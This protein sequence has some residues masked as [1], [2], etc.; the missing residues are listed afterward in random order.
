MKI[1][2]LNSI[3]FTAE[4]NVI[5]KVKSI[6]DTMI[7]NLCIGFKN[8]GHNVTLAAAEEYK[9]I[10][11]EDYNFD[12]LFFKSKLKKIFLPSVLPFSPSLFMYLKKNA[13]DFDF[14]IS[15]EIFAFP[16]LFAC[17][18]CPSKVFVWQE[19][20][21]HNRKMCKIPSK[22]W[23]NII[24][25]IFMRRCLVVPRSHAACMF[26]SNYHR[27]VASNNISHGIDFSK[28]QYSLE[29]LEYFITVGRLVPG[30]NIKSIILRFDAFL[31]KYN[32]SKYR[33]Y[34][35]G[36]GELLE[37]LRTFVKDIEREDSVLFLGHLPHIE[38]NKYLS[39]AKA[40]LLNSRME[41]N[42][43]SLAES[44]AV[45]TPVITNTVPYSSYDVIQNKLGIAKDDWDEDDMME[46]IRNNQFYVDNCF[47]YR[48]QLSI[49]TIANKFIDIFSKRKDSY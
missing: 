30:K 11:K 42:M 23:Y 40:T 37:E 39:Q 13:K 18:I 8:L 24:T 41:L 33:L 35:A 43:I 31:K 5:P 14:I 34:I 10:E 1:L 20:G 26:I 21:V 25:P 6:K 44:V 2:I 47:F 22:I 38:L 12:I 16:T 17:M 48:E 4:K 7:Y 3:L 29:K 19:L 15:S 28:L 32:L 46:V 36:N 9:P 27:N 49:E 45:A